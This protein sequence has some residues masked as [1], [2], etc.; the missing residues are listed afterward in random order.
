M[1]SPRPGALDTGDDLTD[2]PVPSELRLGRLVATLLV[3]SLL[4]ALE[5]TILGSSLAT[6]VRDL[7]GVSAV[8]W[9][10]TAYVLA[11][12]VATPVLGQLGDIHGRRPVFLAS[13]AVFV[14]GTAL[15]GLAPSIVRHGGCHRRTAGA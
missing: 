10:V 11:A 5:I 9:V 6:L 8:G 15:C 12:T 4:G 3:V 2:L 14:V 7:G 1:S 13:L